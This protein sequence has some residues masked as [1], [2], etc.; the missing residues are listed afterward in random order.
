MEIQYNSGIINAYQEAQEKK[1]I[2]G[3]LVIIHDPDSHI[4][5]PV[6]SSTLALDVL[7]DKIRGTIFGLLPSTKIVTLVGATLGDAI[8]LSTEFLSRP[9]SSFHYGCGP[10]KYKSFIRDAHR[11]RWLPGGF[12]RFSAQLIK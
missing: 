7:C 4:I 3:K 10:L 1:P 12:F 8:G 9:Q 5:S 11:S 6:S 2:S